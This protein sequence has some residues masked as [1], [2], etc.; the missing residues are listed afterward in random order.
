MRENTVFRLASITA[1][2]LH[3]GADTLPA[4]KRHPA[5]AQAIDGVINTDF[6]AVQGVIEA[7]GAAPL[8]L[9]FRRHDLDNRLSAG[10]C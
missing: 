9:E 10:T 2:D 1:A 6:A 7:T 4:G 5:L 8:R 3:L